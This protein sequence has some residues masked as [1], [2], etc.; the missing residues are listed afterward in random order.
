MCNNFTKSRR[1][2]IINLHKCYV[3]DPPKWTDELTEL[4]YEELTLTSD[5]EMPADLDLENEM[6][7]DDIIGPWGEAFIYKHL[8]Q[9]QKEDPSI[10]QVGMTLYVLSGNELRPF[11]L[12]E[13]TQKQSGQPV[14]QLPKSIYAKHL[15]L[16]EYVLC[17]CVCVVCVWLC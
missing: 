1:N 13:T 8:L 11:W 4:A 7:P 5:L 6:P 15:C 3:T 2:N 17:T 9:K 16:W 12:S 14:S 10:L